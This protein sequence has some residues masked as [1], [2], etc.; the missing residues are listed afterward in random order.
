MVFL[1]DNTW[2]CGRF[3][4]ENVEEQMHK[5]IIAGFLCCEI[6]RNNNE[7]GIHTRTYRNTLS[8]LLIL[9]WFQRALFQFLWVSCVFFQV[10]DCCEWLTVVDSPTTKLCFMACLSIISTLWYA[11]TKPMCA[12][13]MVIG[14]TIQELRELRVFETRANVFYILIDS[15]QFLHTKIK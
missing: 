10:F 3:S 12:R 2:Q 13:T 14:M 6:N 7:C 1:E 4:T 9:E 11:H 8:L 15:T 5:E